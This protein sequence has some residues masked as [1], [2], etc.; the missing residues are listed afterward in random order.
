MFIPAH[1]LRIPTPEEALPG[2]M[3]PLEVSPTHAVNGHPTTPPFPGM[4]L[5]IFGVGCFWGAERM[6]WQVPG[7]FSTQVGYAGGLTPHPTYQEVCTGLTGH[8]EV[9]RVAYD[10]ARTSFDQLLKLFWENHDPTEGMRQGG[11]IGTQYRSVIYTYDAAQLTAAVHS[12]V[13]FQAALSAEGYGPVTTE[14]GAAPVFFH[15]EDY[16]QQYLHKNPDGHCGL[17]GTGVGCPIGPRA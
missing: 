2:R 16:H 17:R 9:V 4:S 14:I 12:R 15:A 13:V 6:F 3:V 7:V 1:K 10:P 11:D 5:S 8:A